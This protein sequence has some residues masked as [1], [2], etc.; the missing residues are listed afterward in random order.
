[1]SKMYVK[2]ANGQ[3]RLVDKQ[4]PQKQK[5]EIRMAEVNGKLAAYELDGTGFHS[6]KTQT[7]TGTKKVETFHNRVVEKPS[8]LE[9]VDA[10]L[11]RLEEI[12]LAG[13][14]RK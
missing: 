2:D 5:Q 6:C 9:V 7:S 8:T 1:M 12:L 11:K 4:E 10:R 13:G 3:Y 14:E